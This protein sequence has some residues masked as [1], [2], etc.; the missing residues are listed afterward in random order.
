M[1]VIPAQAGIQFIG[2]TALKINQIYNLDSRRGL[3]SSGV[4]GYG[5]DGHFG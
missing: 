2:L 1:T 4:V 5:N 3:P